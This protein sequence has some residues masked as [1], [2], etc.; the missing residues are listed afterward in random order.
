MD[1]FYRHYASAMVGADLEM[2]VPDQCL[3]TLSIR[4]RL[5]NRGISRR[6]R[7]LDDGAMATLASGTEA[8]PS[9]PRGRTVA[10]TC[11]RPRVTA[12]RPPRNRPT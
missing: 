7:G 3:A 5:A 2:L 4:C 1:A 9:P 12:L 10:A 6:R 8:A 11:G